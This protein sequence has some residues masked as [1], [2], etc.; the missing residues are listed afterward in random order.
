MRPLASQAR[1]TRR[2]TRSERSPLASFARLAYSYELFDILNRVSTSRSRY[3]QPLLNLS[4]NSAFREFERLA[5]SPAFGSRISSLSA[6]QR[7]LSSA[8]SASSSAILSSAGPPMRTAPLQG[9]LPA[10]AALLHHD[11]TSPPDETPSLR[12]TSAGRAPP[13]TSLTASATVSPG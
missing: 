4:P 6:A 5:G 1:R 12:A 7:I 8:S 9:V 11:R 13:E 3:P 10:P 2:A